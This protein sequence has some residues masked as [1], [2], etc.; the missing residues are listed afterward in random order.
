MQ[1]LKA[2]VIMSPGGSVKE[3]L[4]NFSVA[5]ALL[6]FVII[7]ALSFPKVAQTQNFFSQ[8]AFHFI[9]ALLLLWAWQMLKF[10]A[11]IRGFLGNKKRTVVGVVLAAL[12][13][14]VVFYSVP[15]GFR[16][17][18][19][20][21]NLLAVS[22]SMVYGHN[23]YNTTIGKFYFGNFYGIANEI[24]T[25]PLVFPYFTHL[26]H[27]VVGFNGHNAFVLNFLILTA[28]FATLLALF[29]RI[30]DLKT[31]VGVILLTAAYPVVT[32]FA[33]SSGFDL[34]SAY[35]FLVCLLLLL[36]FLREPN[37]RAFG[38]LWLS[39][40]VFANVRYES[41]AIFFLVIAGLFVLGYLTRKILWENRFIL[42]GT[43]LLFLPLIWQ[44]ILSRG[45][46]E[47]AP[48]VPLFSF[49][50]FWNHGR[51]FWKSYFDFTR[52]LPYASLFSLVAFPALAL[53]VYW[54]V[55][56][57]HVFQQK[58]LRDA[59]LIILVSVAANTSIFLAHH[60]GIPSHPAQARFFLFFSLALV[61]SVAL[62]RTWKPAWCSSRNFLFAS[63]AFFLFYHPIAV[64]N[65]YT[66]ALILDREAETCFRFLSRLK[67][68]G[69]F[70]IADRPGMFTALNYGAG[71]FNFANRNKASLLSDIR[72][73]LFS[74]V[75]VFQRYAYATQAP[76]ENYR[77]D[78]EFKLTPVYEFQ[79]TATEYMRIS[80]I[81]S[82]SFLLGTDKP[83]TASVSSAGPARSAERKGATTK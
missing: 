71:D 3:K 28:L 5:V 9:T 75:I 35:L 30:A 12:L 14:S 7:G 65:R 36:F 17:L 26:V 73:H 70:V 29:Y 10:R 53:I 59:F 81:E 50:H 63:V 38:L 45:K 32:L 69:V 58:W 61:L 4:K 49:D 83:A 24:P 64:E 20:E 27:T 46:Y 51:D 44:Q 8:S 52:A 19:D 22:K 55:Q 43:P 48:G 74:D 67:E 2:G 79:L 42:A 31:A 76:V 15:P 41:M 13:A 11:E 56:R 82:L 34:C 57:K 25:R 18:S 1:S 77:L 78:P 40:I 66:N 16:T 6:A 37:G 62:V 68:P 47:N 54:V 39:L 60:A 80:R 23:I 33:T 72:N 21:T